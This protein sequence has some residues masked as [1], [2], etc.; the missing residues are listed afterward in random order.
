MDLPINPD[1][2]GSPSLLSP[3]RL[4][5]LVSAVLAAAGGFVSFSL[6]PAVAA[7]AA[8]LAWSLGIGWLVAGRRRTPMVE[9]ELISNLSH[10]MRTPLNGILG[11][12]QVLLD[13]GFR[14]EQR[15]LLEMIKT[16]GE[17]LLRVLN[18]L[19]DYSKIQAGKIRLES[20]EFRLR[21]WVRQSV[22]LHAPQVHRKG[23][24]IAY[25]VA[26]DVPDLVVSD[27]QRLR[28][29]L[30]NLIANAIK[31]TEEG[32]ILVEVRAF[33]GSSRKRSRVRFSVADTGVGIPEGN[34][35]A[36]FRPF[37]QGENARPEQGGLGLGLAI[38]R[39]IVSRMGGSA[40]SVKSEVSKGSRFE[41]EVELETVTEDPPEAPRAL[42]G[43]KALVVDES[44]W[45]REVL[46]RELVALG[47]GV[48]T[49]P[50]TKT[51][52][53]AVANAL[54]SGDPFSFFL[55]DAR[56][57]ED[58]LSLAKEV[59]ELAAI[60][61]V[62]LLLTHQRVPPEVL[63]SHDIAGTL[64]KPVA[65]THLVRAIEIVSR[66]DRVEKPE[67]V[68]TKGMDRPLLAGIKVL[69]AEDHP[70]NRTVVVRL[71]GNLGASVTAASNGREALE[72]WSKERF[73]ILVLDLE[74]PEVD[75]LGV[76]REIRGRERDTKTRLPIVA[77]T[78][79]VREE[80]RE[81]CFRAGMDGFVTKPFE[82]KDLTSAMRAALKLPGGGGKPPSRALAVLD[83]EAAM[84]RA[85]GDRALLAE[86]TGIFLEETPETL[87]RIE[88]AVEARDAKA[89]ER[90]A[91]RLKGALLTLAA[92]AAAEAALELETAAG[93]GPE[94]A[95]REALDRLR[96]EVS[97]LE[98]E[99]KSSALEPKP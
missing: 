92:P 25:W 76:A 53:R 17:S 21:R 60:P 62:L 16:S 42:P 35:D 65:P 58:A 19:L 50:S 55:L 79:H 91:H 71:L 80:Q 69:L 70:V 31:F 89:I 46:A 85:S 57:L 49:V 24:Q 33:P 20:N 90:L 28:Q 96:R 63:R 39:E 56:R 43:S 77:L 5:T 88:Q 11:L 37:A 4:R 72:R 13:S 44:P 38:S 87:R 15:E 22:A 47:I 66:G 10:E 84:G 99:L 34:R 40:I 54:E 36:I 81:L 41:F 78:A 52:L 7:L 30:W 6:L 9:S 45:Q 82:E 95:A 86:L 12:T 26:P 14:P 61:V 8:A 32:E 23:L 98:E 93:A 2:G 74:M 67:D 68:Q 3:I 59:R 73:D 48:E 94:D 1:E 75:G 97:R 51:A 64:T 29:V 27:S 83:R 18:D